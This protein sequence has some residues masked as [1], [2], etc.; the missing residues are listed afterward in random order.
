MT[1]L[2]QQP[3]TKTAVKAKADALKIAMSPVI[4]QSS[5]ALLKLG[6]LQLV[7]DAAK[8]GI[9]AEQIAK[10]L[11]ISQYGVKV[12]LDVG[13]SAELVYVKDDNYFL[14][15]TGYFLLADSMVH[16]NLDFIQD[17]CYQ[18][19]AELTQ[20][21]KSGK[22]EGLKV[23]GDWETIY[24]AISVLPEP[25]K[26]S[27]FKFDHYYSDKVFPIAVEIVFKHEI[28]SLYDI[29]GNTGKWAKSCLEHD[30]HVEV[31]IVDLPEQINVIEQTFSDY[32]H[33]NRLHTYPANLLD[34]TQVI[35]ANADAIWMSQFLDCFSEEEILSILQRVAN[36]M[37]QT[38]RLYIL[39]LFWDR[40]EYESAAFT[41]NC[42]SIY[43]TCM[44]NGNS[45]MYHSKDLINL[46]HKAGLY[47]DEDIDHLGPGH[48]LLCCKKKP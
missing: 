27:W 2:Y 9:T 3:A 30:H 26:S 24:P 6:I 8:S 37:S 21:I 13:L 11:S 22:A 17:V 33:K 20:S 1:N 45:R 23:F 16:V 36:S 47:V 38:T 39:E 42:T 29:G 40:Q 28:K 34:N 32:K 41:I 14:D 4:F 19:L 7:G 5:Y 44:A 48:T 31:T 15:K 46:I 35:P 43:F 12:L 25:A 18:G 10:Q